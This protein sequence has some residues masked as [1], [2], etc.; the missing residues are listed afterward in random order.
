VQLVSF[1]PASRV[2]E[3]PQTCDRTIDVTFGGGMQN[4][5]GRSLGEGVLHRR[6]VRN[7]RFPM[8]T[9][10]FFSRAAS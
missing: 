1:K 9:I 7:I 2:D 3:F 8:V 6:F 5:R 10:L 4:R